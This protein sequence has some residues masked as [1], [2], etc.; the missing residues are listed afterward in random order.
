MLDQLPEAELGGK[1]YPGREADLDGA[2]PQTPCGGEADKRPWS[3]P[4]LIEIT[5]LAVIAAIRRDAEG[6]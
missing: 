6:L 2:L 3:A 4:T 5:D 1:A